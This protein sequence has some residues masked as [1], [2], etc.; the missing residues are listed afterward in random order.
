MNCY[1]PYIIGYHFIPYIQQRTK[2]L[3]TAQ[4]GNRETP[5]CLQKS[6]LKKPRFG[7]QKQMEIYEGF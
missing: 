1:N 6:E 2:V 7:A 4:A 5:Q 3:V